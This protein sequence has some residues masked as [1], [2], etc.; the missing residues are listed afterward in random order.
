VKVNLREKVVVL[1]IR[2]VLLRDKKTL[3]KIAKDEGLNSLS[4]LLR[5]E[6]KR[7]VRD[8]KAA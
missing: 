4:A 7:L 1:A 3:Y 2:G 5:R 6:I 8:R